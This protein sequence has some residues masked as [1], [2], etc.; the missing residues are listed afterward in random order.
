MLFRMIHPSAEGARVTTFELFFDLVFVFAFTQVTRLMAETHTGFGILQ[1]LIVLALLWWCWICYGWLANQTRADRGVIRIGIILATIGMFVIALSIP[2]AFNDRDGG[3][4]AP[5]VLVV[6]Y[7]L[8]RIMHGVLYFLAAGADRALRRQVLVT[9]PAALIPAGFLL[10]LGIAVGEPWQT[11]LWLAALL[12]DAA[13]V[14]A[15]SRIG[16]RVHSAAH[17]AD[18]HGLIVILALGESVVSIGA[19]VAQ[20]PLSVPIVVGSALAV[21]LSFGMWWAYFERMAPAAEKILAHREGAPR[22]ALARDAYTYLHYPLI[23]GIIVAALG[24]ELAMEHV[25]E[26]ESLGAFGGFALGVG[27]AVY[28]LSTFFFWW[29]VTGRR[30]WPRLASAALFLA[31][32]PLLSAVPGLV[33]LIVAGTVL[34][35]AIVVEGLAFRESRQPVGRADL[36]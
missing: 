30:S 21:L 33:A 26:E 34:A 3:L 35:I 22:A 17:W 36:A 19:G 14:Y 12:T 23:A 32:S 1:A 18:R 16:W 31:V 10:F 9:V 27:M 5:I 6:C 29:R 11:W 13:I 24:V 28:L 8:V 25:A 15:T 2:E 20:L 7:L 4:D